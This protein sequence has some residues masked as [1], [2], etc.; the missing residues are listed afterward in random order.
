MGIGAIEGSARVAGDSG[1]R[2]QTQSAGF[3]PMASVDRVSLFCRQIAVGLSS[4]AVDILFEQASVLSEGN[5]DGE[6]YYGSTMVTFDLNRA[7]SLVTDRCDAATLKRLRSLL[8]HDPRVKDRARRLGATEAERCAKAE[9]CDSQVDLRVTGTG[10]HL[11]LDLD[12]EASVTR[13]SK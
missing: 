7:A 11:H 3:K 8:V 5:V 10:C 9:L 6:R 2:R 1:Y 13:K 12:V 4:A